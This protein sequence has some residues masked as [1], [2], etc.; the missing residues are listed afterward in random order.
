MELIERD[1]PLIERIA[2]EL[3]EG[4]L[5]DFDDVEALVADDD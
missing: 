2:D 1:W 4:G 3:M 5:L